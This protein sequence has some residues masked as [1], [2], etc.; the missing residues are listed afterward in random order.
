MKVI[1]FFGNEIKPGMRAMRIAEKTLVPC[2]IM[3]VRPSKTRWDSNIGILS[4]TSTQSAN[5]RQDRIIV[6]DSLS[7]DIS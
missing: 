1:D 2:T 6:Q 7:V 4:D 5:T 3:S